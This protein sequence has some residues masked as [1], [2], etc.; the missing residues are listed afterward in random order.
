MRKRPLVLVEWEDSC[1][2]HSWRE[3]KETDDVKPMICY[4]VGWKVKAP[5]GK[6]M[7]ASS[8][9]SVDECADRTA[10]PKANI[11]SIKRLE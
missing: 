4:S 10:I 3:E 9:N 1:T 7:I 6:L 8:R 11:K 2:Y 5:K